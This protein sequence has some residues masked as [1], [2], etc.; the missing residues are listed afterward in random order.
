MSAATTI[1]RRPRARDSRLPR[2]PDRRGRRRPRRRLARPRGRS[3]RGLDG[4]QRGRRAAR[5]R[6]APVRGQG[7]P[8]RGRRTSTARSRRRSIGRDATDQAAIDELLI[9]LDGTPEQGPP[10]GE[11]DPRRVAGLRARRRGRRRRCRC[12]GTSAAPG[13]GRCPSRS[14]TS[15]TA[16]STPSTRPTSRSSWSRRSARPRSPTRSAPARRSSLRL[17]TILHD[18][19]HSTGQGDE[20]GFAPSLATNEAAVEFILRAIEAAGYRPGEDVA[21]ALDPAVSLDHRR[22]HGRTRACPAGTASRRRVGR[23]RA[24]S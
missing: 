14:S 7:R 22:G 5:R 17:R 10:R 21:I 9:D 4:R 12:T 16:A 13:R 23:S 11:R 3:L 2:Q 1:A 8:R 20:G 18:E 24:A 15:S 19:G 6:Q